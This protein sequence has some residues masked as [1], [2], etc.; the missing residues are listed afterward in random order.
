M[1]WWGGQLQPERV[2]VTLVSR[3]ASV[4]LKESVV[5]TDYS[6]QETEMG[7]AKV[8]VLVTGQVQQALETAPTA[9]GCSA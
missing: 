2:Q 5:V 8:S 1:E 3:T 7:L 9:K 6:A 4:G